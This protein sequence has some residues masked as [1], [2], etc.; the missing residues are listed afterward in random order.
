MPLAKETLPTCPSN[1]AIRPLAAGS[2]PNLL[3]RELPTPVNSD[4]LQ[5]FLSG[6]IPS[7]VELLSNGFNYGFPLHYEGPQDSS[8]AKNLLSAIQNP[9][10]VDAKLDKEIA[11][12]R[13]AGP[14]SS[15]PF[16]QFRISPLGLVPKKTEGEFRF[17]HHLSF[18]HGS[19]L[20]DGISSEFTSVSYATVEDA[21]HT[22]RTV[23]H[24]CFMAKTDIKNAFRIIP[25]QPQDYNL[26]GICWRGFYYYDRCMPMGCSSSCK[27]LEI[28]SSAIEWIAQEKLHVDHILHLLDDFLI[29]SPSH[30]LCKQKLDLFLML[31]QYLGIPM[32]PEK[33]IGPSSTIS[34]A[35]IE[36]D[37]VLMEARLPPDK[38]V[39]CQDLI[40]GFLRR[41][42]VTLREIQSLTGLLNFA[43]TVVVPGRAFLRRLIDL[44]IGIRHPHF[45]IRLTR[46][47]K[48][49]LKVW[50][51]FLSGFNG[52]SFF[53]SVDWANSH[54]LKLYTDASGAIGF[55]AVFGRHWCYGEWPMSWRHRNIAFLEFYPIVL[56]LHLWGHTI[57]NQRV[58]F[59]TDNE[60]LVHVINKQTCRDKDLM[61]FVRKLVLVCLNY[62]ICFKAKHVPGL[63]NK[64]ADSLSRLQLQIFKQLAPAYMHK[65]P[66]VIPPHLQPLS[67][68]P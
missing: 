27:T 37:S 56:S 58:L 68:L 11:A 52:R 67:W 54:H 19:P 46:K 1:A 26:L 28:F 48:E 13:I 12:H 55:G 22:I 36:L 33:T 39:K 66:T 41:R 8:C 59:F 44:T 35:G 50:H 31:C 40:S 62:N 3:P 29:V 25:I 10:A 18:P 32:A 16:P 21:I 43:C 49:D 42:K 4:R 23:G 9:E 14:Y 30:D 63:Q 53:L 34:F 60:A 15:P 24:G 45:L 38:L 61:F 57:K 20:N 2:F 7:L 17:I 6:Y 65:A 47:V 64:L 51:Q 5:F